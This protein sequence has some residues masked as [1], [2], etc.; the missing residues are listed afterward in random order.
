MKAAQLSL[1]QAA[2]VRDTAIET[3]NATLAQLAASRNGTVLGIDQAKRD[4]SK[5]SVV[6]PFD[7]TV[8]KVIA[9]V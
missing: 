1:A 2:S 8:T 4:Y 3:K 9:T 6:S 5:L 7:G